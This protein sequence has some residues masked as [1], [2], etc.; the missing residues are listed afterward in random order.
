M[1]AVSVLCFWKKSGGDVT[2]SWPGILVFYCFCGLGRGLSICGLMGQHLE[3][4]T[5]VPS[6]GE[7]ED[8]R[9]PQ[10]ATVGTQESC[11]QAGD[12]SAGK[13]PRRLG[14]GHTR[15]IGYL[16]RGVVRSQF[17][18]TL[19]PGLKLRLRGLVEVPLPTEPSCQP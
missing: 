2:P 3:S 16:W 9:M 10:L 19:A 1:T 18:S 8:L 13:G 15:V 14:A 5:R 12:C 7:P 6:L 4:G 17:S 11:F